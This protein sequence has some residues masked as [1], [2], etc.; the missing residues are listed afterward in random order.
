MFNRIIKTG[1]VVALAVSFTA[2]CG[3]VDQGEV[4][5]L[6]DQAN[7]TTLADIMP[8]DHVLVVPAQ[9]WTEAP[10]LND[11]DSI[12]NAQPTSIEKYD[13][14]ELGNVER[15]E[16][17]PLRVESGGL[18]AAD[19]ATGCVD[20]DAWKDHAWATC[21]RISGELVEIR[22]AGECADGAG[23]T[24][25][26]FV[27]RTDENWGFRAFTSTVA[28]GSRSCKPYTSFKMFAAATCG[29][30]RLVE[31]QAA[32][33]CYEDSE[34]TYYRAASFTCIH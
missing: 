33:P 16:V 9:E 8:Q 28:G 12:W 32:D 21:T 3:E 31:I 10:D 29:P 4:I 5:S 6:D 1:L 18:N 13:A 26:T 7:F 19:F 17:E 27:C 14:P 25:T 30:Q 22:T 20:V 15:I 11:I 24:S 2:A 23:A 34:D